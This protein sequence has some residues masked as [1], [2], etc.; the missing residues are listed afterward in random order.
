MAKVNIP[1]LVQKNIA[2]WGKATFKT[3]SLAVA[4][5]VA[6][7]LVAPTAK[8]RYQHVEKLTG[9]PWFAIAMIHERE[10]SQRWDRQLGQGDPLA[11][12]SVHVPKGRGP[13]ATW[14]EGAID[15]LVNCGP[16]AAKW[17][18]WTPGGMLTLQEMYNGLGYARMGRSSA[19][20][21]SGSNQYVS[22]KYVSDGIYDANV[23]D[24]QLGCAVMLKAMMEL[25]HV[26][27]PDAEHVDA[28]DR[29]IVHE[30]THTGDE[31]LN[32]EEYPDPVPPSGETDDDEQAVPPRAPSPA[33]AR[34]APQKAEQQEQPSV[35]DRAGNTLD[36]I[37]TYQGM[38]ARVG[39]IFKS[40][41]AWLATLLFGTNVSASGVSAQHATDLLHNPMFWIIIGALLAGGIIFFRWYDH[42]RG[43]PAL[44]VGEP[45]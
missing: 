26:I 10:A 13:F 29:E 31:H 18:D 45:Q 27:Y 23:V 41:I 12:V 43:N 20:I 17:K 38:A 32:P 28:P 33:P 36:K 4:R 5:K 22:G 40:K 39:S 9:V 7:R 15:A 1:E 37:E 2:R 8:A 25:D 42:G 3:S 44:K 14:E 34:P 24:T 21:W 11:H 35:A 30:R 6:Q 19:Y 16:Y